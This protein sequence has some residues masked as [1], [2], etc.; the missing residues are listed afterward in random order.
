MLLNL[1]EVAY[2]CLLLEKFYGSNHGETQALDTN[3]RDTVLE[4]RASQAAIF[5]PE[6]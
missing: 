4:R 1:L 6:P 2:V 3:A 5:C